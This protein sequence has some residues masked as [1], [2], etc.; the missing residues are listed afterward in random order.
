LETSD[1]RLIHAEQ[2][3]LSSE[4]RSLSCVLDVWAGKGPKVLSLTW[5][6]DRPWQP[7]RIVRLVT[8]PWR[9]AL[10][11]LVSTAL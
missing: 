11:L 9:E 7:A 3:L 2:A 8:G 1:L 5:E 10:E 4:E 6:P